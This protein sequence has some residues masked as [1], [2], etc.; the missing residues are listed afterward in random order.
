MTELATPQPSRSSRPIVG[1][2]TREVIASGLL[3][4]AILVVYAQIGGHRP[5]PF[6]DALYLTD[7]AWVLRGLT[8]EGVIWAFTNVDAA[9]WHPITWLSH[10]VDQQIFG[11][12]IGGHMIEN[13][14]WHFGNSLLVYRLLLALGQPRLMGLALALVFAV[15]PLNVES[16]AWLSQRKT[17]ISTFLLLA[18]VIFYLDW[19]VTRRTSTRVLLTVAYTLSLMAKAMGVALPVILLTFEL[20]QRWPQVRAD[21]HARAWPGLLG[22]FFRTLRDLWPLLAAAFLIAAVTFLAQRQVGAVASLDNMPLGYRLPNA[23]AAVGTY[24][25]TFFLPAELSI[26]YPLGEAP[27]WEAAAAGFAA[28][29]LGTFLAVIASPRVPLVAFGWMWFLLSL[30]PVIGLVQVGSQSHADR[31]MYVPMVGLLISVGAWL[32]Q[33]DLPGCRAPRAAWV[34]LIA[35]FAVGMGGH[36]YAYT[37]L[38]RNP[39]TAYRRSLDVSGVSY[40]MLSNLAGTLTQLKYYK[41]AE[42][43]SEVSARL[44]P[45]RILVV[46][47]L[48]SVKGLLGKLDEAE[49]GFRRAMMLEPTNVKHP[50]MLAVVLLQGGR[51]AEAEAVLDAALPLLPPAND[52]RKAHQM[53]RRI[54]LREVPLPEFPVSELLGADSTDQ[55]TRS[56]LP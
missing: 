36:A 8:W 48:A 17:Q 26:F 27:R 43:Y 3:G 21:V 2:A 53:I 38:W 41:T 13:A 6:D 11:S 39:E 44:W 10:M 4:L 22:H 19:R 50:Y 51:R 5:I 25:R 55:K 15:H 45:D 54:M 56:A 35:A 30:L 9:N 34:G 16:V 12:L 49:A 20:V 7:N 1:P 23:L 24:L 32:A 31:Y 47:N 28:I 40:L 33:A 37:M 29:S 14:F 46:V 52:W 42:V 18:T